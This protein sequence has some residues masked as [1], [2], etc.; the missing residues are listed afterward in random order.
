[1]NVVIAPDSFKGSLLASEVCTIIKEA[2][3]CEYPEATVI[4]VPMADGGEGTM[5]AIV[6]AMNGFF[7]P[8]IYHYHF[9]ICNKQ[10]MVLSVIQRSLK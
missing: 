1:M 6:S 4:A 5:E 7:Q 8:V 3:R 10:H 9:L 2:F